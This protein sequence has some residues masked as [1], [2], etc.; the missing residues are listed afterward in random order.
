MSRRSSLALSTEEP[1]A[2]A[3]CP[4]MVPCAGVSL[5]TKGSEPEVLE[6]LSARPIHTVIIASYIRD[7]GLASERN[8]GSFHG[9]RDCHGRLEGVALIGHATLFETESEA[10]LGAFAQLIRDSKTAR[11]IMGE[12]HKVERLWRQLRRAGREPHQVRRELLF[13]QRWPVAVQESLPNLRPAVHED[14]DAV[15]TTHARMAVEEFGLDDPIVAD[16]EGFLERCARRIDQGRVWVLIENGSL[17]FKADIVS[18]TP[19][20][21]YLEGIYVDPQKRGQGYGLRCLSHLSRRLLSRAGAICLFVNDQNHEAQDFY[22]SAGYRLQS[23]YKT[24][25]VEK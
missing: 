14:L 18:E 19:E 17:V 4:A 15:M 16:P 1:L 23:Y 11:M 21:I 12:Q 13:E 7:N 20:A 3:V 10:A 9:Y 24:I 5:L 6:F 22:R 25:V 8:R 2:G